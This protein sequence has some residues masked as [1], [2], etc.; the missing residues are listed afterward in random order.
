MRTKLTRYAAG[1][2]V[3]IAVGFGTWHLAKWVKI[4]AVLAADRIPYTIIFRDFTY[5]D[6]IGSEID[7]EHPHDSVT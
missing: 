2:L 4:R 6:K 5:R 7:F 3:L 1:L